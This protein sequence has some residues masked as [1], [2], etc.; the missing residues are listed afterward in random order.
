MI[1]CLNQDIF[2]LPR[3]QHVWRGFHE[4]S[5]FKTGFRVSG[6][7]TIDFSVEKGTRRRFGCLRQ[8]RGGGDLPEAPWR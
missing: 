8:T 3:E 4:V 7:F 6:M 1:K 2:L 5:G